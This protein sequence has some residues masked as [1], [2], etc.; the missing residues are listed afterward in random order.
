MYHDR[1]NELDDSTPIGITGPTLS[2]TEVISLFAKDLA[3]HALVRPA[4]RRRLGLVATQPSYR[5]F[6]KVMR[7]G[8]LAALKSNIDARNPVPNQLS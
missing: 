2:K 8:R 4:D 7:R 1:Y 3:A 5:N 6:D